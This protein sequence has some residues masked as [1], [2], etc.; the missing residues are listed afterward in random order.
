[1]PSTTRILIIVLLTLAGLSV[2]PARAYELRESYI[3]P[4]V[5]YARELA[6]KITVP[7]KVNL[8]QADVNELITLPGVDE[9][10]ALKMIRLRTRGPMEGVKDLYQLPWLQPRD[11]QRLIY[12]IQSHVVF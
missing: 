2:A 6:Q 4:E 12:Q 8:N 3:P 5:A 10:I 9:N 1:M 7:R 11:V